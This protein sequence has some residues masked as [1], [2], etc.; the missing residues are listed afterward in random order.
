MNNPK[1]PIIQNKYEHRPT[2][3]KEGFGEITNTQN[4]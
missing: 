2:E 4:I 1:Q 3:N